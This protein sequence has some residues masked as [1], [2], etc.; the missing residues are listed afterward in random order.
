MAGNNV[1][2]PSG[3]PIPFHPRRRETGQV[4]SY[5]RQ[6]FAFQFG[7]AFWLIC[8]LFSV[9]V[10]VA[11]NPSRFRQM[12]D[13]FATNSAAFEGLGVG[14]DFLP[15]Y[16]LTLDSLAFIAY[17]LVGILIFWR[18]AS[19]WVALFSSLALVTA[20]ITIGRPADSLFF[21]QP[22]L[23]LPILLLFTLG[24]G[25]ILLFLYL[26]PNGRVTPRWIILVALAS[27]GLPVMASLHQIA[28]LS[29]ITWPP[30]VIAPSAIPAV[31]LA[32][33]AQ[34]YRYH[35]VASPAQRQ[36][37]KWVLYGL[38]IAA[39]GFIGFLLVVPGL[40]PQVR[41]PGIEGAVYMLLGI[42]LFYL[43]LMLLPLTIGASILR[44]RL[45]DIDL[46]IRQTLLY[47]SLTAVVAGLFAGAITFG[48]R[49]FMSLTGQ[50][51]D[52]AAVFATLLVVSLITPLK[53]YIQKCVDRRCWMG[54]EPAIRL[55][56]FVDRVNARVSPVH[57]IQICRRLADESVAAFNAKGVAVYWDEDG[58]REMVYH[59]AEWDGD[60][61]VSVP[62]QATEQGP[63]L[64][65]IALGARRNGSEYSEKD[66]S[67]L[68]Q[69]ASA[70][71]RAIEQ[72]R[73]RA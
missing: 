66:R 28:S 18:K 61:R 33:A 42:P 51:S 9:Y 4:R 12:Q 38:G 56:G 55:Q 11:T 24:T 54:S 71:A 26:F 3:R 34:V 46:I 19:D 35:R 40:V 45:W 20:G 49:V 2:I 63:R 47:G 50:Q 6:R 48:Q 69:A 17:A 8:L 65:V 5:L 32:V 68:Q 58:K 1:S 30:P 39:A 22:A 16:I 7:R 73:S 64:G 15:P 72:D 67:V 60:T 14:R 53:D 25:S 29:T 27:S 52:I 37:T 41:Q 13:A 70:V 44:Y 59:S 43:S 57:P 23:R 62:L 10:F 31:A 36:Q 21:V